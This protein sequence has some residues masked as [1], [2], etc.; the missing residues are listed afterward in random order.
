MKEIKL[1]SEFPNWSTINQNIRVNGGIRYE[2]G[3]SDG[4]DTRVLAA[5]T[6]K[7][8]CIGFSNIELECLPR[9][10]GSPRLEGECGAGPVWC[11]VNAGKGYTENIESCDLGYIYKSHGGANRIQ[12]VS[13]DVEPRKE[14]GCLVWQALAPCRTFPL[15]TQHEGN[16]YYNYFITYMY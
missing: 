5:Q 15:Q 1:A 7:G 16:K 14:G 2:Y 10:Q 9:L 11:A 6:G 3:V 13:G 12:C 8:N 4:D